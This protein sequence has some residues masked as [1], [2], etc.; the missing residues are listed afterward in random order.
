MNKAY[1]AGV[2]LVKYF[3][4]PPTPFFFLKMHTIFASFE[5]S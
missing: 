1:A 2:S 4:D 5:S 3:R